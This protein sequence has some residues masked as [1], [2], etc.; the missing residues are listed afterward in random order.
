MVTWLPAAGTVL[1]AG[2]RLYDAGGESSYLMHGSIPAWRAF[3]D[4]MSKGS[5]IQQLQS[6]LQGLGYFTREPDGTF[7]WWTIRAI[8]A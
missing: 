4:G 7:G 2:D 3:E 6:A 1:H 8:R 5:D